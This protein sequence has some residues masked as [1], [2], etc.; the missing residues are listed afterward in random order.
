[1]I[2]APIFNPFHIL[3]RYHCRRACKAPSPGVFRQVR[4]NPVKRIPPM[5]IAFEP[6]R[7]IR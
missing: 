1:M 2:A 3:S 6:V 5:S 7:M 4:R